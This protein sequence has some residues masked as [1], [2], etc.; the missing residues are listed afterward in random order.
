MWKRLLCCVL[1]VLTL[2]SCCA[3][4]G[5]KEETPVEEDPV[6]TVVPEP[7]PEPE[8]EPEPEPTGP[9]NPLTGE[10]VEDEALVNRRPV[11]VMLN[12]IHYAMPQ[13]GVSDADMIFEYNVEGG[14]TRMVGFFQDPSKIGTIGSVRSAR[15]CFIETVMGMDAIYFHAG[16]S[17]EARQMFVNLNMDHVDA[18]TS[19]FW[20]DENRRKTM[21]IEHTLMTSGEAISAYLE[22]SSFRRDHKEDYTYPMTYVENATPAGGENAA[23]VAVHFSRYKTDY[24]DYDAETGLYMISQYYNT[25]GT[26]DPYIDGNTDKQVGV[27]NLLVLRTTVVNSGDS[28]G[29]M[30]IDLKGSNSG[31][32]F[33]GGKAEPITWQKEGTYDPFTFYHEDGTPLSLQVGHTY[34]CVID[35]N[36]E[37]TYNE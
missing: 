6:E 1:T 27:P 31:V 20:R 24:F 13:H 15:A 23:H 29:H 7:Q 22:K 30:N 19:V 17:P 36:A 28:S 33:C 16:G 5:K 26:M 8:P 4:G 3:C 9:V 18:N 32:Y 2:L 12:D 11:A 35:V 21:A 37:L 10:P 34:V 25:K 14:I